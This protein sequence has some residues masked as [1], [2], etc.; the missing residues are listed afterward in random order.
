M[1]ATSGGGGVQRCWHVR[2][3]GRVTTH[4]RVI[5]GISYGDRLTFVDTDAHEE[6]PERVEEVLGNIQV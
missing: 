5:L 4:V 3:L 1:G 6:Q 2:G